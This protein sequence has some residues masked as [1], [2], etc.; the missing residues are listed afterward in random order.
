MAAGCGSAWC[1]RHHQPHRHVVARAELRRRAAEAS[2]ECGIAVPAMPLSV[3]FVAPE[4]VPV[5]AWRHFGKSK[6]PVL[7]QAA[8][9]IVDRVKCEGVAKAK[10]VHA[11]APEG[12]GQHARG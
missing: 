3:K 2:G 1:P 7:H 10:I 5:S 4:P 11:G 12:V 9:D 8:E 6:Q